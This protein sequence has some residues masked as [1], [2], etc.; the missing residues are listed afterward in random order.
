MN[1]VGKGQLVAYKKWYTAY[2]M[3]NP[4]KM[5]SNKK[6]WKNNVARLVYGW[7][8]EMSECS[9]PCGGGF[10]NI[11]VVCQTDNTVVD[12]GFCA[13]IN[14]PGETGIWPCNTQ[15]C[16][17]KWQEGL[18]EPCSVT[19]GQGFQNRDVVCVQ[20]VSQNIYSMVQSHYCS[21][22][23]PPMTRTC[24]GP[25]CDSYSNHV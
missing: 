8:V 6:Q 18:W 24:S 5:Y 13:T 4:N 11:T 21:G 25:P 1:N 15:P 17:G 10:K 19:C 22:S 3:Q 9:V 20:H 23:P 12:D 7:V 2:G 14:K 16:S